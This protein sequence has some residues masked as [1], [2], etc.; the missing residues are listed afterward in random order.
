[1]EDL[2]LTNSKDLCVEMCRS[3]LIIVKGEWTVSSQSSV[4]EAT[5]LGGKI[6]DSRAAA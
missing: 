2:H 3:L 5:S 6:V 1:M 4:S